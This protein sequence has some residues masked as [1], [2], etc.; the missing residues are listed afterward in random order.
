VPSRIDSFDPLP[1]V[2]IDNPDDPFGTQLLDRENL[3]KIYYNVSP[4]NSENDYTHIAVRF[5]SVDANKNPLLDKSYPLGVYITQKESDDNG[6]YFKIPAHFF[7]KIGGSVSINQYKI[8]TKGVSYVNLEYSDLVDLSVNGIG[9]NE[10]YRAQIKLLNF[11]AGIPRTTSSVSN[12][13][14]SFASSWYET[15]SA[16]SSTGYAA[17]TQQL[18]ISSATSTVSAGAAIS[19]FGIYPNTYILGAT[20]STITISRGLSEDIPSQSPIYITYNQGPYSASST[21]IITNGIIN[22][23]SSVSNISE[24]SSQILMKPVVIG[25]LD[26]DSEVGI[27]TFQSRNTSSGDLITTNQANAQFYSFQFNYPKNAEEKIQSY[28]FQ[29]FEESDLGTAYEDSSTIEVQQYL[30]QTSVSYTN[31]KELDNGAT[32][33]LSITFQTVTGFTYT[34]RYQF[35][36]IYSINPLGITF[37]ARSDN[38]NGRI[39]FQIVG[40]QVRFIP[41][42][43]TYNDTTFQFINSDNNVSYS[44]STEA[45]KQNA[46]QVIG[47]EVM[48]NKQ[49]LIFNPDFNSW[50]LEMLVGGVRAKT[51]G[52]LDTNS[53]ESDFMFKLIDDE[54][55]PEFQYY[56]V[57]VS[58]SESVP[59]YIGVGTA[60]VTAASLTRSY[61]EFNLI[62]KVANNSTGLKTFNDIN[63]GGFSRALTT[64]SAKSEIITTYTAYMSGADGT[65]GGYASINSFGPSNAPYSSYDTQ[66]T[67]TETASTGSTIIYVSNTSSISLFDPVRISG[68]QRFDTASIVD[69]IGP[70]FVIVNRPIIS[71]INNGTTIRFG[72]DSNKYYLFFGE[73]N[74]K[75]FL[76]ARHLNP[77]ASTEQII[78]RLNR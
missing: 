1:I 48:K 39:E 27:S 12:S 5:L 31:E 67:A 68:T 60:S 65:L 53:M 44:S 47:T 36:P 75:M 14:P 38:E 13:T 54:A 22:P 51:N 77:T 76:Y 10:Y 3:L 35:S 49:S 63:S 46:L 71:Q 59:T 64:G 17:G 11:G 26:N 7:I 34:K 15:F 78:D 43:G 19:G 37:E 9:L 18:V 25:D 52:P 56:L 73:V 69:F 29:I 21:K 58:Y 42:S 8:P 30:S 20:S 2:N 4:L 24:W 57:P 50:S 72:D 16:K 74:G 41:S 45:F 61:N 62:K 66:K 40:R 32:Y 55:N 33:F 28:R 6:T 23:T 70:D